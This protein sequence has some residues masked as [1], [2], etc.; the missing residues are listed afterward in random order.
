MGMKAKAGRP[1]KSSSHKLMLRLS[2]TSSSIWRS[3]KDFHLKSLTKNTTKEELPSL[4]ET[5]TSLNASMKTTSLRVSGS[6]AS[7]TNTVTNTVNH[8]RHHARCQLHGY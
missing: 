5:P 4:S 1:R 2:N 8:L 6:K 7:S 3:L